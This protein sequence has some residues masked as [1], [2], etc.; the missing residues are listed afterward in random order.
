MR[1]GWLSG[2][3]ERQRERE[4]ERERRRRTIVEERPRRTSMYLHI[5]WFL[6]LA[7][8]SFYADT[9]ADV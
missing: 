7:N 2:K 5:T 4:R 9:Q 6:T 3:E 8:V 1:R